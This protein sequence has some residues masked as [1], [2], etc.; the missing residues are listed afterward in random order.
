MK[1]I[2]KLR[3]K[4]QEKS[5][6]LETLKGL[7]VKSQVKVSY[8]EDELKKAS[9][10]LTLK[11]VIFD[12]ILKDILSKMPLTRETE[13]ALFCDE[14]KKVVEPQTSYEKFLH[15]KKLVEETKDELTKISKRVSVKTLL[16]FP[17]VFK[18]ANYLMSTTPIS[19]IEEALMKRYTEE[20]KEVVEPSTTSEKPIV[21]APTNFSSRFMPNVK[22]SILSTKNRNLFLSLGFPMMCNYIRTAF[23][24][25]I[26]DMCDYEGTFDK[27][28]DSTEV[29]IYEAIPELVPDGMVYDKEKGEL[30]QKTCSNQMCQGEFCC[31]DDEDMI[32]SYVAKMA[33]RAKSF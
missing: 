23:N 7:Y 4:V 32:E 22:F 19:Q 18:R 30:V 6:E 11:K 10:K 29:S 20:E 13:H 21:D 33:H 27:W 1:D 8:L 28:A 17:E 5:I 15:V 16:T 12:P 14:H 31:C 24:G 25:D 3:K 26:V 2:H 9:E